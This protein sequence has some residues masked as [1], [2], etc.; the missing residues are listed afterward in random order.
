MDTL[1]QEKIE[2]LLSAYVD[3][4]LSVA[5]VA[6][7]ERL[8]REK[9][10]LDARVQELRRMKALLAQK[11]PLPQ[12]LGF[13][14]RL[15]TELARREREED[16]LLPFPRKLLPYV[17][18]AAIVLVAT[19]GF[20]LFE[21]Q[22]SVI[23]YVNQQAEQVQKA[24]EE[25]LLGSSILPLFSNIDK[26]QVLQFALFGTLPL[27]AK[28]ETA[29]RVDEEAEKGYRID[30]GRTAKSPIPPVT[31]NELFRELKPTPMQARVIDSL[32]DI[33]KA[34]IES[35]VFIA[36]D[37]G[38][39]IDPDLPKFNRAI[40]TSIASALEPSQRSRFERFLRIHNAPYKIAATHALPPKEPEQIIRELH[41][42]PRAD[43]FIVVTPDTFLFTHL[44]LSIEQMQH[45]AH[46]LHKR[47]REV[48]ANVDVLIRK[49]ADRGDELRRGIKLRMN[50][51]RVR[52]FGAPEFF[53]IHIERGESSAGGRRV[54]MVQPRLPEPSV[55][56]GQAPRSRLFNYRFYRNDSAMSFE[57]EVD[58]LMMRFL[59][60]P[61]PDP[62]RL[63]EFEQRFL[64]QRLRKGFIPDSVHINSVM[65]EFHTGKISFD[66]LMKLIYEN[67][68]QEAREKRRPRVRIEQH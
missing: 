59:E 27:D 26:N 17:S 9:P 16:N 68:L 23:E 36:E 53:S 28:A 1:R 4:E 41:L 24:V 7:V 21:E 29:L 48:H 57:L 51:D 25:N 44:P 8:I 15:S 31:V 58:S 33:S 30:V 43:R 12:Q 2:E 20:L 52:V 56:V 5:E 6:E 67:E 34:K 10:E 46:Q 35:S 65:E 38:M 64:E 49:L 54:M 11:K 19:I 3:G 32:L 66:S 42:A 55:Y 47:Q 22:E 62:R 13:W 50:K 18:F 39:A 61:V 40:L 37:K 63:R 60:N 45:A 14:T